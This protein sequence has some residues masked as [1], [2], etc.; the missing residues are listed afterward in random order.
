MVLPKKNKNRN[1]KCFEWHEV[2]APIVCRFTSGTLF[3]FSMLNTYQLG[4]VQHHLSLRS[5]SWL[6]VWHCRFLHLNYRFYL[7]GLFFCTVKPQNLWLLICS[8]FMQFAINFP[9]ICRFSFIFYWFLINDVE[10]WI[11]QLFQSAIFYWVPKSADC[12]VLLYQEF[13]SFQC[14]YPLD[15]KTWIDL[16][17]SDQT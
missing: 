8:I 3:T 16:N 11:L 2:F 14:Y 7:Y 6:T 13:S 9:E 12:G 5:W 17:R 10:L 4:H 15:K 1:V